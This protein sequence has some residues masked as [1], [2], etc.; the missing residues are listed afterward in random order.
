MSY[1]LAR[2]ETE[3][4]CHSRLVRCLAGLIALFTAFSGQAFATSFVYI[5]TS[6]GIYIGADS[7]RV[8][9]GVDSQSVCKINVVRDTVM[10]TWGSAAFGGTDQR[11]GKPLLKHYSSVADPVLNM[12]NDA[13]TKSVV[14][15]KR[16]EAYIRELMDEMDHA[17]RP[18]TPVDMSRT[19][20]GEAFIAYESGSP[21][22][23]WYEVAVNDWKKRDLFVTPGLPF[24]L[25]ERS[26]IPL[27]FGNREGVEAFLTNN[28]PYVHEATEQEAIAT[29][30]EI[31][32][33]QVA[34]TPKDVGPPFAIAVLEPTSGLR[35]IEGGMCKATPKKVG[36]KKPKTAK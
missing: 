33:L 15:E 23:Y 3:L 4:P 6:H 2:K 16:T 24:S 20:V 10:L 1:N 12:P 14:L 27:I 18:L 36:P 5:V 13:K 25:K 30:K 34:Y 19:T 22:V 9:Y 7:M 29:I 8:H 28:P 11:T 26:G 17:S 35:W 21:A 32:K 31:L